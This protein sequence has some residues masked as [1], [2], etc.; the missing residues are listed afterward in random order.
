MDNLKKKIK[1]ILPDYTTGEELL[2]MISHIVGGAFGILTL[3]LCVVKAALGGNTAGVVGSAIYGASMI[4]VYTTSSIYHGLR[5]NAGKKVFRVLDH[6]MIY[7]LIA[8]TYTPILLSAVIPK[9][10]VAGWVIFAIEWGCT[11]LAVT[12][13]AVDMKKF[14]AF[15]MTCYIIMGWCIIAFAKTALAAMTKPGF[16]WVLAGGIAYTVGAICY[17][18]GKKKKYIHGVFHLFVVLGSFLQF[19]GVFLYCL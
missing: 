15:S 8:G 1:H 2:N 5:R 14:N 10:P 18:I 9:F 4:L 19:L 11:A 6:C 17:G 7:L 3:V 13:T 12:L 16:M